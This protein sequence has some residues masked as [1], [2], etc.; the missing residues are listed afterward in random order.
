M[1]LEKSRHN[2]LHHSSS[3]LVL[4]TVSVNSVLAGLP[5]IPW[6]FCNVYKMRLLD[7]CRQD[8]RL[9]ARSSAKGAS[10]EAPQDPREVTLANGVGAVPFPRNVFGFFELG[11][12][13]FFACILTHD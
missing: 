13:H 5:A 6:R 3:F 11:M 4:T 7:L 10:I 8:F 12:V 9:G 1:S 2:S